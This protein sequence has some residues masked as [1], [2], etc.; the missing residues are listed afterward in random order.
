[1]P[2]HTDMDSDL[3]EVDAFNSNRESVLLDAAG[4]YGHESAALA[5][6]DEEVMEISGSEDEEDGD[7]EGGHSSDD[8]D[9]SG[10]SG[11]ESGAEDDED[12]GAWGGRRNYYGGEDDDANDEMAAEARRQQK[13]H[14]EELAMADYVD[15]D[16]MDDWKTMAAQEQLGSSVVVATSALMA[17]LP[18][19]EQRKLLQESYPEFEPL[20]AE[21]TGLRP[22]LA[23][24]A[25]RSGA[26]G[27]AQATALRAYLGCLASYF[28]MFMAK[29]KAD[30]VFSMKDEPI[31]ESLLSCREVWR[32]A[33]E[34]GEGGETQHSGTDDGAA[35]THRQE[36]TARDSPDVSQDDESGSDAASDSSSEFVDAEEH[37][38]LQIDIEKQRL[39]RPSAA[40]QTDDFTEGTDSV[41]LE[42]KQRRKR[43]LRFY[44]SKIDQAAAK[45]NRERFTGDIDVPYK[46][47]LYERQ[48][49]LLEEARKRG[50]QATGSGQ[51]LDD[52]DFQLEDETA[53]RA[54]N[55]NDRLLYQ[56]VAREKAG[57]KEARRN[58]HASAVAAA[59]SGK[60]Q[61]LQEQL[62]AD[63]KRAINYQI[64]KNRGLT[65]HKKKDDRNSRV[66][67]RKKYE[68]A[69]KKLKSVRHVYEGSL[70]PYEGEKTGI[71]KGLS[72]SVRLV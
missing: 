27:A 19:A 46:E 61:E 42:E 1:M 6:S 32:Q 62:G 13:K 14:L 34:L 9:K 45:A 59:K 26:V 70:G 57:K 4:G 10:V 38:P 8:G 43:T 51:E 58:A 33:R 52:Q 22:Q 12:D 37:L 49:R 29:M 15:E 50:L 25:G 63:G 17:S 40:A 21:M 18:P 65:A 30:E 39:L 41:D 28:A 48:Q 68:Q 71:K 56:Q 54:V 53:A 16:T 3:D 64:L 5:S 55:E 72:R 7:E 47:R 44:T 24:V 35:E 11:G 20:L 60:L 31:M 69:K 66:K 67:K 2:L 23:V 36:E